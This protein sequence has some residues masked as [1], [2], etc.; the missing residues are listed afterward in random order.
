MPIITIT[1]QAYTA[2]FG[3]YLV[4]VEF[5]VND[6]LI[7]LAVRHDVDLCLHGDQRDESNINF[8]SQA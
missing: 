7:T 8:E 3:L 5:E 6:E 4:A 1:E 2:Q